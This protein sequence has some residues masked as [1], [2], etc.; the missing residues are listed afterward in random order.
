MKTLISLLF[1]F[2]VLII[3]I[4]RCNSADKNLTKKDFKCEDTTSKNAMVCCGQIFTG[5][6]SSSVKD[7][8]C[9]ILAIEKREEIRESRKKGLWVYCKSEA[10]KNNVYINDL[11]QSCWDKLHTK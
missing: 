6:K 3:S 4:F 11:F 1:I 5:E 7:S 8:I 9:N 10:T 2:I